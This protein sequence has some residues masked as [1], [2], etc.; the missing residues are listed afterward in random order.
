M[1]IK[2]DDFSSSDNNFLIASNKVKG[3]FSM[4]SKHFHDKYEIYYLVSGERY[5]FI[6]D[7][8]FRINKGH[9]VL[10][11]EGELHRTAD[12]DEPDHERILVYFRKSFATTSNHSTDTIIDFLDAKYYCVIG[13]SLKEQ[14]TVEKIF[15]EMNQEVSKKALGFEICL[16][17]LLMKL[18]V[19]I[20]R[21][22]PGN[23]ERAFVSSSPKHEKVSEIV[24]FIN[25][26]YDETLSIPIISE[27]FF[28]SP[29]YLSRIFK[30]TTGFTIVEYINNVRVKAAQRLLSDEST[31]VIEISEKTG[32]GS[33]AHFNRAFKEISGCSPLNYRKNC[34]CKKIT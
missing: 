20:V 2:M 34:Q 29:Y 32:F 19:H 10:V 9:L 15:M 5:Y 8:V 23:D 26:H 24:K 27:L 25:G 1:N 21:Y 33:V 11:K 31:K 17:G 16:Q 12:T 3:Y 4:P 28:I 30:E 6:K 22:M 18:L 13:L 7:S 14:Q